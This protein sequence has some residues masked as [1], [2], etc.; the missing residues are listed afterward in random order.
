M[1]WFR[2]VRSRHDVRKSKAAIAFAN[3]IGLGMVLDVR[4]G[5]A[6]NYSVYVDARVDCGTGSIRDGQ[7]MQGI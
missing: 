5:T 3:D 7:I 2:K 6:P 1:G 4:A